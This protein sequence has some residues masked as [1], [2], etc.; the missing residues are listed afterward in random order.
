M[1]NYIKIKNFKSISDLEIFFDNKVTNIFWE[2]WIWKTNVLLSI[3]SVF[4]S[5]TSFKTKDLVQNWQK[6]LY[7]ESVFQSSQ[8]EH[9]ISFS[10]DIEKDKKMFLLNWKSITRPKL[11]QITP[12]ITSFFP[13]TMNLFYLSPKYRRDF[14]DEILQN[15]YSNYQKLLKSYENILKN[16]NKMLKSILEEK[17]KKED[18]LFWDNE[19]IKLAS[20]IYEYRFKIVEFYQIE[21]KKYQEIFNFKIKEI[22]FVYNTKVDKNNIWENIRE[23]L[24]KNLD[25]DIILWK[26][27]IWPHIDDFDIIVDWKSV[28]DFASRWELKTIIV[29]L[30]IIEIN[31][32]YSIFGQKP[33]LLVDDIVSELDEIHLNLIFKY[34]SWLQIISTSISQIS[35]ENLVNFSILQQNNTL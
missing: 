24:T 3:L 34:F 29:V 11:I 17:S 10:Y 7:L 26:T 28:I 27:H 9:K 25:R 31:F 4:N 5:H 32:I 22:D 1:L 15:V 19:F 2:N 23:Y 6:F 35:R 8:I 12:K 21:I 18:I 30:K 16:R 14:L 20:L 13:I 33:I